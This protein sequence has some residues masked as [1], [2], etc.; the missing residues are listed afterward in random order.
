MSLISCIEEVCAASSNV[1]SELL[2]AK[3]KIA[4]WLAQSH[5]KLEDAQRRVQEMLVEMSKEGDVIN[6][7]INGPAGKTCL[8]AQGV[9]H[10]TIAE[11]LTRLNACSISSITEQDFIATAGQRTITVGSPPA[12]PA[13][14]EVFING[15]AC[16]DPSDYTLVGSTVTFVAP[17][18]AGDTGSIRVFAP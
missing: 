7:V 6:C 3:Q 2:N 9:S 4:N 1:V 12:T 15:A 8:T 11:S 14:M 13:A 17:L 5:A 10:L 18:T 16:E